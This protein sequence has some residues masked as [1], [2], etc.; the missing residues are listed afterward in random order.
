MEL[1]FS[2]VEKDHKVKAVIDIVGLNEKLH[3]S[4]R[5]LSMGQRQRVAIARAIVA[6]PVVVL[7]DE[8]TGSLDSKNAGNILQLFRKINKDRGVT[9]VMVTHENTAREYYDR[10]VQLLDGK[11]CT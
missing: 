8:P 2:Q 3:T 5:N 7:A 4:V 9:I 11:I 10:Q 1:N 6:D